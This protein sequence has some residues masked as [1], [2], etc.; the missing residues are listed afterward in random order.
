MKNRL[1][2]YTILIAS[3]SGQLFALK[4]FRFFPDLTFLYTVF[5]G[6]FYGPYEGAVMGLAAGFLRACFSVGT[7]GLDMFMLPVTAYVSYLFSELF[8]KKNPLFQ[9]LMSLSGFVFFISAQAF[10]LGGVYD[11]DMKLT[12][13]LSES[14]WQISLTVLAAPF[15]FPLWCG[16]LRTGE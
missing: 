14:R 6:I 11:L 12:D 2:A 9:V 10:F 7:S 1:T 15:I 5:F 16:I 4:Y 8:Y 13:V 3:I